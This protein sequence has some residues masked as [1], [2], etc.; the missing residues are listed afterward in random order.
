MSQSKLNLITH[1]WASTCLEVGN[2]FTDASLKNVVNSWNYYYWKKEKKKK[3]EKKEHE[4]R[5]TCNEIKL[6]K[7]QIKLCHT[8]HDIDD[9]LRLSC[10]ILRFFRVLFC[11]V[12]TFLLAMQSVQTYV[13]YTLHT[14]TPSK[15]ASVYTNYIE[16][17]S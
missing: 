6:N 8:A 10:L 7:S 13:L 9:R 12:F 17:A 1:C 15:Q 14:R 11:N 4:R 2:F 3:Q 16:C 5:Y